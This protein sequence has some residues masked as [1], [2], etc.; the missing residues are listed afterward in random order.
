MAQRV[1]ALAAKAVD[2]DSISGTHIM[3]KENLPPVSG[4][5]I[6]PSK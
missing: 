5:L 4:L 1:K 6:T 3:E 2:L